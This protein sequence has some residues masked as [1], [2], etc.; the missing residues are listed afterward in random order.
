MKTLLAFLLLSSLAMADPHP[1]VVRVTVQDGGGTNSVGSGVYVRSG[2]D[3]A[4]RPTGLVLTNH[5]VI[6]DQNGGI[7]VTFPDGFTSGARV[8]GS[9]HRD[10]LAALVIWRPKCDPMPIAEGAPQAGEKIWIAGYGGYPTQGY[11]EQAG[12]ARYE[13]VG[14]I[15]T[16]TGAQARQGDSGGPIINGQGELAGVLDAAGSGFTIGANTN[17]TRVFLTQFCGP[18]GCGRPYPT[19]QPRPVVTTPAPRPTAPS[20]PA[21]NCADKL[22]KLDSRLSAIEL[23]PVIHGKDGKDGADGK[24]IDPAEVAKLV[25]AQLGNVRC[26]CQPPAPSQSDAPHYVLVASQTAEYWRWLEGPLNQAREVYHGIAVA[27]VPPFDAG[28]MPQLVQYRGGVPYQTIQ[29]RDDVVKML[30]LIA[31]NK[32]E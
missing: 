6:R 8:I 17:A 20:Q 5:H 24:S 28:P 3:E 11:L 1:A 15:L 12:T 7:T 10:D 26:K 22:A 13:F 32:V 19:P 14:N 21:C 23:Q 16:V 4:D 30:N 2:S 31:Q 29:G 25:I 9:D 27:P 18:G